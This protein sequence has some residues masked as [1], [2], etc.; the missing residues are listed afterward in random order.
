MGNQEIRFSGRF[1]INGEEKLGDFICN[2]EQGGIYLVVDYKLSIDNPIGEFDIKCPKTICGE[3]SSGHKLTMFDCKV[4]SNNTKVFQYARVCYEAKHLIWGDY[5]EDDCKFNIIN[6]KTGNLLTWSNLSGIKANLNEESFTIIHNF[7]EPKKIV[8]KD[9]SITFHTTFSSDFYVW[10]IPEKAITDENLN[11]RIESSVGKS[12]YELLKVK[13][14]IFDFISFGINNN[15]DIIDVTLNSNERKF[16]LKENDTEEI[17]N[18]YTLWTNAKKMETY[19]TDIYEFNFKL[20]HLIQLGDQTQKILENLDK[21]QPILNLYLMPI[22]YREI[23]SEIIFLNLMQA[24]ESFHARCI[25]NEKK[26]FRTR[27]D[28]HFKNHSSTNRDFFD[29]LLW[30]RDQQRKKDILLISRIYDLLIMKDAGLF[31]EYWHHTNF[32]EILRDT[33]NYYTHYKESLKEK[34]FIGESLEKVIFFLKHL[35]E[36]HICDYIGVDIRDKTLQSLNHANMRNWAEN[37]RKQ[38]K[39]ESLCIY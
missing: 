12:I 20:D 28:E 25:C 5:F 2:K 9:Y 29:T 22:R 3:I 19:K 30:N 24:I 1:L 7:K 16:K 17:H 36:Y 23:P 11:I 39:K 26:D 14:L 10:P 13:K 15:I 38:Y 4:V 33:R 8:I 37:I 18:N 34:I 6:V 21:L 31:D 27:I 32:P 35:L